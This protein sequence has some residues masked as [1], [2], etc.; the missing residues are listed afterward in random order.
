MLDGCIETKAV[1]DAIKKIEDLKKNCKSCVYYNRLNLIIDEL[2][3]LTDYKE[4]KKG[5]FKR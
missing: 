1:N 5:G 3:K 4:I 2:K